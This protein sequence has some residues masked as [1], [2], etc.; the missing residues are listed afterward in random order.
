MK[1]WVD[2][3]ACPTAVREIIANAAHRNAVATIFVA[4]KP[5]A[6]LPSPHISFVQVEKSA[7]A[8]DVYIKDNAD[9]LDLII[10]Q[11]VPLAH[12]VVSK[13]AVAINPHGQKFTPDN[14]GDRISMRNLMQD[15]RDSGAI[16]G[17]P[18]QFSDKDKRAFANTF[19]NELIKL[20]RQSRT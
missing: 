10:T 1:I 9:I 15:L 13:G 20:L 7:D 14:I 5:L 4:N 8:A 2:A 3:D 6:I 12:A 11:D 16:T 19:S 18:K 17:G